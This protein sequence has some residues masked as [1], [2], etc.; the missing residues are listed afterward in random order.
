MIRPCF[1][2]LVSCSLTALGQNGLVPNP[3]ANSATLTATTR[4]VYEDVVVRDG[5]GRVVQGLTLNDFK[6]KEDGASQQIDYF[7]EHAYA[8]SAAQKPAAS[9]PTPSSAKK[10]E[11]ITDFTNVPSPGTV[12]S[13]N[14]VLFDL[15]NTPV[16]DQLPA[17][18]ALLNFL[19]SLP[20]GHQVALFVL[21]DRLHMF[22]N[23]TS[24]SDRLIEASRAINP[25]SLL[26][27]D[28]KL[29]KQQADDYVTEF[30][31]L[32][33]R[34]PGGAAAGLKK[35]ND[36]DASY[37]LGVR[38]TGTLRALAQ[39][40]RA[41][42]GYPGRK[43]LLWLSSSFPVT[44]G[45]QMEFLQGA[46]VVQPDDARETTNLLTTAQMAVYP[47]SLLGLETEGVSTASSGLGSVALGGG[48]KS[49]SSLRDQFTDRAALRAGMNDLAFQTGGIA[50]VGTNDFARALRLSIED[51]SNY[52]TLAYRPQ[53]Q[54]ADGRFHKIR[55]EL[56]RKGYSLSYRRG[57]FAFDKPS[58]SNSVLELNAAVEPET[59]ESTMLTLKSEVEQSGAGIVKVA[60]TLDMAN[61]TLVSTD[62]G[63][64]RGKLLVLLVA[65]DDT[66]GMVAQ[67]LSEAL[68]QT[69][70]MLNLD[71]D[72]SQYQR[73]AI[74]GIS[75]TQQLKLKP[76]SYRL[77]LGVADLQSH[78]LGTLDMPI[79][80]G[81]PG[82]QS[83]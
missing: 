41:T 72:A 28:S 48:A 11:S 49:D 31:H 40:A 73:T 12:D 13:V 52:Y 10:W 51:G 56:V 2:L 20:P 44:L 83:K 71:F 57:Y 62:D 53:N 64:R 3:A 74:D 45:A 43:N 4:L 33:G 38:L 27:T 68:P 75:F 81:N 18:R 65:Y 78:R 76:G 5:Q 42:S 36:Q 1:L 46:A 16:V 29:D 21:S 47:I 39:L 58:T 34:D 60:S 77:R 67:T 14:I 9:M 80:V 6:L 15:L 66:P 79:H 30:E 50:F 63:H 26:L 19:I 70:A 35:Q 59:P 22:Q 69:F 61:M 55:V 54:K 24:S 25:K 8:S 32:I 37:N 23:F 82:Q 7:D 17:R